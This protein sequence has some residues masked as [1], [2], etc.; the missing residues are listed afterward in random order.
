[1]SERRQKLDEKGE[2]VLRNVQESD[3]PIFF[4]HQLDSSAN[5]MTAF[6]AKDPAD[7]AAFTAHWNKI[8]ADENITLKTILYDGEV[9]GHVLSFER[10]GQPEVSYWI[11]EALFWGSWVVGV[12][13]LIFILINHIYFVQSGEPGLE[14]RFGESYRLY[15]ANVPRW[16]P[17]LKLRSGK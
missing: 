11:G 13:A 12:W 8:L 6:T 14:E 5:Y 10:F 17:R 16:V 3:L 4:E 15:R 1:M 9:A 7:K 2:V